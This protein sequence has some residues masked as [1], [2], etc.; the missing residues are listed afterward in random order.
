L[1]TDQFDAGRTIK[2]IYPGT[3]PR[4]TVYSSIIHETI[5]P[6]LAR[7]AAVTQVLDWYNSRVGGSDSFWLQRQN[8]A[9]VE[10]SQAKYE[11]PIWKPVKHARW[12]TVKDT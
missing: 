7:A 12:S 2:I 9:E 5:E 3:H 8:K 6:E 11:Y 10:L 1:V 4:L